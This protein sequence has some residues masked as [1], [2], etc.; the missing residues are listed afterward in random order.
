MI[1]PG[2]E[3]NTLPKIEYD[4]LNGTV[5]MTGRSI[6]PEV[7]HYFA[8]FLPY[9]TECIAKDPRD[10]K[11]DI[12]LEY[13]NTSTAKQL[14][15]LFKIAKK[16]KDDDFNVI[17]NWYVDGDDEDMFEAGFDYQTLTGLEFNIIEKPVL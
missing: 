8:K 1:L 10:L 3:A 9:F 12:N 13:F 14:I 6:S 16:I 7:N 15:E 2:N 4:E 11:I 5:S 17:I